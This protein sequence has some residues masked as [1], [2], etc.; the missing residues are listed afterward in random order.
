MSFIWQQGPVLSI[1]WECTTFFGETII[2]DY[3]SE[4]L[5]MLFLFLFSGLLPVGHSLP[6]LGD[7]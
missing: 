4:C 7:V 6:R 1:V 5:E 3:S 2:V